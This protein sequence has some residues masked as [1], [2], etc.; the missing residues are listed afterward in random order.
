MSGRADR[1]TAYREHE[2][3]SR[4]AWKSK[5]RRDPE[6]DEDDD[7]MPLGEL[8]QMTTATSYRRMFDVDAMSANHQ[9]NMARIYELEM[10]PD[11]ARLGGNGDG[12]T[13]HQERRRGYGRCVQRRR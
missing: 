10:P 11:A 6:E 12:K 4:D 9:R 13:R 7:D 1:E 2:D 3:L 5:P 8:E